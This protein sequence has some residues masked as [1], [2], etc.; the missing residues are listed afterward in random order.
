[1]GRTLKRVPLDF[2]WPL[3]KVWRGYLISTCLDDAD[4]DQCRIFAKWKDI[5]LTNY[6]CPDFEP[7]KGP[8]TGDGFQLWETTSEGSPTSPVFA[9]L[10]ELCAWCETNATTFASETATAEK[11]REMLITDNVHHQN[12][13]IT[14]I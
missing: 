5:P 9:T 13:N 12:G 8:P 10:D 7:F 4:C 14:F 2:D 1:M 6:D 11:W 3:N